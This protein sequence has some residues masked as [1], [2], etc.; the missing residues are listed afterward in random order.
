MRDA[1]GKTLA[2][3]GCVP[4]VLGEALPDFF[5]ALPKDFSTVLSNRAGTGYFISND[6]DGKTIFHAP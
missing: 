6:Q 3:M 2:A 1:K 5:P 4:R